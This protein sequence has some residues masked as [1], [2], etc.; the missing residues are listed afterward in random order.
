M[1]YGRHDNYHAKWL[2]DVCNKEK[3]Y[4]KWQLMYHLSKLAD[5]V[6]AAWATIADKKAAA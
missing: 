2:R 6:D 5:D 4:T 1:M 3:S